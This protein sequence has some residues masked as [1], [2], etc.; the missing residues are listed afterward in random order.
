CFAVLHCF[1][2]SF[3]TLPFL[4]LLL[5]PPPLFFLNPRCLAIPFTCPFAILFRNEF[6][7]SLSASLL[8]SIKPF[9]VNTAGILDCRNTAK[10]AFFLPR[11]LQPVA[12]TTALLIS[13]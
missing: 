12:E 9:S 11:F 5:G 13:F 1:A 7:L 3:T 8:V 4:D 6:D 2:L 10:F